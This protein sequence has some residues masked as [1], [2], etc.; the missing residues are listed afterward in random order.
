[1][2]VKLR[3]WAT[4]IVFIAWVA[5]LGWQSYFYGR[6][7]VVSRSQFMTADF[8]VIATMTA[9]DEGV[10][11]PKVKIKRVI[12]PEE[13]ESDMDGKEIVIGNWTRIDGFTGPGDYVLPLTR[14][15]TGENTLAEI[16][17]SPLSE[18][19]RGKHYIYPAV[20]VVLEQV[21][22]IPKSK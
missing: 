21:R 9:N 13:R 2:G 18:A 12:W 5:W 1:V 3:V 7:P 11:Q 20:P 16:P 14:G 4:W 17:R 15:K 22:R 10:V 6:F 19:T 8:A